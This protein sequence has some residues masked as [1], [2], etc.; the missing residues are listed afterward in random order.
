M[1]SCTGSSF[2][3]PRSCISATHFVPIPK[4]LG[5]PFIHLWTGSKVPCTDSYS[6][7]TD[8]KCLKMKTLLSFKAF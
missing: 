6:V 7:S 8:S 3:G 2:Q 4:S 5:F 1:R